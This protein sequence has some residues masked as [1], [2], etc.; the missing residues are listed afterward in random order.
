MVLEVCKPLYTLLTSGTRTLTSHIE[1]AFS[2]DA[3]LLGGEGR[4]CLLL[5][6]QTNIP[7]LIYLVISN[8]HPWLF[9]DITNL[10]LK[11]MSAHR[12]DDIN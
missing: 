9:C 7:W 4:G 1:Y 2:M 5:P 10:L 12:F 11:M 8:I 3:L 6:N